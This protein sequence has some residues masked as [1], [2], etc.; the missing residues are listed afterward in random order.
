M[1]ARRRRYGPRGTAATLVLALFTVACTVEA[2]P[3]HS[4]R[5]LAEGLEHP[6]GLTF[7]PGD[8][9]L[10]TERS[11]RLLRLNLHNNRRQVIDGTPAVAALGQGGLLDVALHPQFVRNRLVYLSYVK[12]T[13]AGLT[14]AVGRGQL[15]HSHLESFAELFSAVP[16]TWADQHFGSRLLFD[17]AGHLFVTVGDRRHR[18]WAQ[19]LDNHAGK[20]LRL[21]ATGDAV[22]SNP[23]VGQPGALPEIY[24]LGHRNPQGL[25]LHPK[26][27]ELWLHEH[28]PRGGDEI[29]V[30]AAGANYGWPQVTFGREYHGPTIGVPPP[31]PGFLSPRHHWTPSIAPSGMAF[32]TGHHFPAWRGDLFVGALVHRHLQRLRIRDGT[33]RPQEKLLTEQGW[34]IRDVRQGPDGYLYVL[35]DAA[36]GVLARIEPHTSQPRP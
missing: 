20:V 2:P 12:K 34:R 16:P 22:P 27:G 3:R 4:L 9:A 17:R 7:L 33:V 21:T 29:N 19:Q 25:A 13:D 5:I 11:G 35:T 24:S 26:T 8:E 23:F 32:Y 10:V 31:Q 14:T 30:L 18:N 28:G 1:T 6:W 15:R 36:N